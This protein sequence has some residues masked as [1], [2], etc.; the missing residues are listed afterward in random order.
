MTNLEKLNDVEQASQNVSLEETKRENKQ[1]VG[2]IIVKPGV[3]W[4]LE[5]ISSNVS[6]WVYRVLNAENEFCEV[7]KSELTMNPWWV[8]TEKVS[9][10]AD[11]RWDS[12]VQ[13]SGQRVNDDHWWDVEKKEVSWVCN[14]V[15]WKNFETYR[16][17]DM[18]WV[19]ELDNWKFLIN[20]YWKYK[21]NLSFITRVPKLSF[22]S[23]SSKDL[24]FDEWDFD[25]IYWEFFVSKKWTKC[26]RVLP[27]EKAKHILIRDNWWGA[28]NKYR[29]RTLPEDGAVYYRRASSN[30]GWS[31]YD[32]GVYEKDF[33][34]TLSEDDI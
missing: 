3:S 29:W 30:G 11:V 16:L 33:K 23:V 26:F 15:F 22:E 19:I 14:L 1:E 34:N 17:A 7:N 24:N 20:S 5:I 18:E 25:V 28:F 13:F 32:Y 12:S 27:K 2:E 9:W 4:H 6:D 31:G 21:P 10:A 8:D